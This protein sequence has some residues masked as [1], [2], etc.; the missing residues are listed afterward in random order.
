MFLVFME[1][2]FGFAVFD[3][4]H[5]GDPVLYQHIFWFY[6]HPVVYVMVLP[7][8]GVMSELVTAFSYKHVFGY[9]FIAFSS[10]AI[11]AIGFFVWGHHMF[12]NGISEYSGP[13]VLADE[14]HRRRAV[15]D[16]GVQL[17]GDDP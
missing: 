13:D 7:G 15:G 11:A 17:G 10:L 5:G 1:R 16:Q 4:A 3:P 2:A 8:M 6:S 14:L 12:Y 9:K